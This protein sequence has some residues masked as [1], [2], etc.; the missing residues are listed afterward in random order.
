VAKN[1]PLFLHLVKFE[2]TVLIIR[3]RI[4]AIRE[5]RTYISEANKQVAVEA[6]LVG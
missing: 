4:D 5:F 1:L 3:Y 6:Y 2:F